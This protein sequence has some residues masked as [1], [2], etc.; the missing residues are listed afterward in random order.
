MGSFFRG[1]VTFREQLFSGEGGLLLKFYCNIYQ[2]K[3]MRFV[4]L[5]FNITDVSAKLSLSQL[6]KHARLLVRKFLS[7]TPSIE[8]LT[9]MGACV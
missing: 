4:H 8:K 6:C 9:R 5:P 7:V 1:D 3:S 2:H